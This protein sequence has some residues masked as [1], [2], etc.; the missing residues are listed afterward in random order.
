MTAQ[1]KVCIRCR[2][3]LDLN[4]FN[5]YKKSGKPRGKCKKC[6]N[7]Y[8]KKR[9]IARRKK[10]KETK[11]FQ[12]TQCEEFKLLTQ[13][14]RNEKGRGEM[15][16]DCYPNYVKQR[17][18]ERHER[19]YKAYYNKTRAKQIAK[20]IKWNKNNPE[21][22]AVH[23]KQY[24]ERHKNEPQFRI[25]ENLGGRLRK[26]VHKD[27]DRFVDFIGCSVD[28]LKEWLE[29]NFT[30]KMNW[31]NYGSYWEIDHIRPLESF[32]L[33]NK[34]QCLECWNWSNL[35]PLPGEENERKSDK[36]YENII[37]FYK[38]QKRYFM[39]TKQ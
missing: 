31:D 6:A 33:V 7:E 29:Y 28:F 37:N 20:S 9:K 32:D 30:A 12:C 27:G 5:I 24:R 17:K 4:C 8:D 18:K 36:I 2:K 38:L 1:T 16:K 15:C 39:K 22:R 13:K 14:V 23:R 26:L 10:D 19:E 21:R 25:K 3:E 11:T 35:A 34:E